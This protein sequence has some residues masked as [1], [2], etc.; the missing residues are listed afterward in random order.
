MNW[1]KPQLEAIQSP[2]GLILVNAGA[3]SGKTSVLTERVVQRLLEGKKLS[4]LLVVTFTRK[5]AIEMKERVRNR[6]NELADEHPQLLE[7]L[8]LLDSASIST[9]DGFANQI[10]SQFGHLKGLPSQTSIIDQVMLKQQKYRIL[11]ELIQEWFAS[12]HPGFLD[13]VSTFTIRNEKTIR[14]Q[15]LDLDEIFRQYNGELTL[16]TNLDKDYH[17]DEYK[18]SMKSLY[19]A[20]LHVD[21]QRIVVVIESLSSVTNLEPYSEYVEKVVEFYRGLES[22]SSFVE[23]QHFFSERAP[24]LSKPKWLKNLDITDDIEYQ[25][26]QSMYVD[27]IISEAEL[28]EV[29]AYISLL[30]FRK[31]KLD[32]SIKLLKARLDKSWES[33]LQEYDAIL[34][35]QTVLVELTI[36]FY[37]RVNEWFATEGLMDYQTMANT[38]LDLVRS[39]PDVTEELQSRY[40]E[41]YVDEYQDTSYFQDRLITLI[42][43][44]NLFCVG[45][46]KQSIYR[47]RNANP[48][49][50][51][52]KQ[53]DFES[54][55]NGKIIQMNDNFRSHP[56]VIDHVNRFFSLVMKPDL[57]GVLYDQSQALRASNPIYQKGDLNPAQRGL[58]FLIPT[59]PEESQPSIIEE[60]SFDDADYD[61]NYGD[62]GYEESLPLEEDY[63]PGNGV[64]S[65]EFM[66]D[67]EA[68]CLLIIQDIKAKLDQGFLIHDGPHVRPVKYDDFVILMDRRRLFKQMQ[69]LFDY[70]NVPAYFHYTEPFIQT[71]DI[72]AVK[73]LIRLV[74]GLQE[75]SYFIKTFRHNYA[76]VARSFLVDI[77]DEEIHVFLSQLKTRPTNNIDQVLELAPDKSSDLLTKAKHLAN[78][79]NE[80]SLYENILAIFEDFDV[81]ERTLRLY[82]TERVE[83]RLLF[84]LEK[85][86]NFNDIDMQIDDFVDYFDFVV[87]QERMDLDLEFTETSQLQ[88]GKVNIMTMHA[89]KGLEFPI[90]YYPNLEM[91]FPIFNSK[92]VKFSL[93]TG[94][95]SPG[96]D[97]GIV[98]P[99][100]S[101]LYSA[102]QI[103]DESSERLR[104][105]YVALTRAKE[106]GVVFLDKVAPESNMLPGPNSQKRYYMNLASFF[107]ELDLLK[108]FGNLTFL[109]L[110]EE[111]FENYKMP[112]PQEEYTYPMDTPVLRYHSRDLPTPTPLRARTSSKAIATLL[113]KEQLSAVDF[114]DYMHN[115]FGVIDY[116]QPIQPQLDRLSLSDQ[117]QRYI[118]Q[119]V[120]SPLMKDLS[121]ATIYHEYRFYQETE[122]GP[123]NGIIDLLVVW[124]THAWIIDFKLKNIETPEYVQQV[125]IYMNYIQ[126][127]LDIKVEGYLYSI[128]TSQTKNIVL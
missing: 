11:D 125:Q 24:T 62:Y 43:R 1:T 54:H 97:D 78:Q 6:I 123:I 19:E 80:R 109:G 93:E 96:F 91:N 60:P 22:C 76:S 102:E 104:L 105:L 73:N 7:Q 128:I 117:E 90:V 52:N 56:M 27:S 92:S 126:Q 8:A 64:E 98:Y 5:A 85:A 59:I 39:S 23:F 79:L 20:L 87:S 89:S 10:V 34:K 29:N 70:H 72:L 40:V 75:Q 121:S 120:E 31:N 4:Q 106:V 112:R 83:K 16:F 15:I 50:F 44:E 28:N 49:L 32:Y 58:V 101:E 84:M 38:A 14:D 48:A 127:L 110:E 100:T 36:I 77:T 69:I 61:D 81:F 18:A 115:L 2:I 26:F 37:E 42:S 66:I 47:F 119:F 124:P 116:H 57:G 13:Y 9:I 53:R 51:L 99:I 103:K 33:I 45:D 25:D 12:E 55:P 17:S 74:Y 67:W 46:I 68:D 65:F 35:Y 82:D 95:V 86:R 122:M 41:I 88:T 111:Y 3:G 94:L 21:A 108:A 113:T 107:A 71:H 118:T 114:G 30:K 63:Q